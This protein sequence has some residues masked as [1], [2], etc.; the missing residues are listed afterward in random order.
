MINR[1]NRPKAARSAKNSKDKKKG[2]STKG[3]ST[4][5]SSKGELTDDIREMLGK[6]TLSKWEPEGEYDALRARLV[7]DLKPETVIEWILTND[8]V[9]SIWEARRLKKVKRAVAATNRANSIATIVGNT[10][11]GVGKLRIP[12]EGTERIAEG[13]SEGHEGAWSIL[14]QALYNLGLEYDDIEALSYHTVLKDLERINYLITLCDRRRDHLIRDVEKRRSI[15]S[16]V[17]KQ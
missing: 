12:S 5:S 6:P 15:G 2:R 10:C 17:R 4:R 1:S 9:D 16:R 7:S 13:V 3:T 11:A 8:I 14:Y